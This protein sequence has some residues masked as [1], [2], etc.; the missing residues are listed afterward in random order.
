[1]T[2][3]LFSGHITSGVK[4]AGM[5]HGRLYGTRE[6]IVAL[7]AERPQLCRIHKTMAADQI[8][9]VMKLLKGS[10]AKG[11]A[12]SGFNVRNNQQWDD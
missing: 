1:M 11:L 5:H 2:R 4:L 8:V 9:V 6:V 12:C 10:G 7:R 3:N